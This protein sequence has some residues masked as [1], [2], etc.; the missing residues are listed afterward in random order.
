MKYTIAFEDNGQG[1]LEWDVKGCGV[2]DNW[3]FQ[4][5]AW[6]GT[7]VDM[8]RGSSRSTA[9]Y[10]HKIGQGFAIA[11]SGNMHCKAYMKVGHCRISTEE[12]NPDLQLAAL[13][14]AGWDRVFTDKA[15]SDT[16]K[17]KE[18]TR[19]LTRKSCCD[20]RQ[21]SGNFPFPVILW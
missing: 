10:S 6:N 3:L 19:C 13:K 21:Q 4:A 16:A 20:G 14:R 12:L 9:T 15:S 1:F 2:V 7:K 8:K 18:L 11:L 17:R 5:L